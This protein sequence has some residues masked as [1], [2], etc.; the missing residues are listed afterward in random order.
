MLGLLIYQGLTVGELVRLRAKEVKLQEGRIMVKGT[1]RSNERTLSLQAH[2]V[3]SLKAYLDKNKFADVLFIASGQKM[4]QRIQYMFG[5]LRVLNKKV[6]NAK[7]IR[8]S[9]II[10][11][12]KQYNLRQVQYMVGHKYVSSTERYRLNHLDDLKNAIQQHHPMK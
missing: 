4:T 12:L 11:W 2:Q 5:Q 1:A 10:N 3:L 7:Q 6:S 9:V 8:S